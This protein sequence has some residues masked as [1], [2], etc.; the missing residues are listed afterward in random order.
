M[1]LHNLLPFNIDNQRRPAA[2]VEDT[3]NKPWRPMPTKRLT[4]REAKVTM[5]ALYPTAFMVSVYVGGLKQSTTL[6]LLGFWYN[7]RGGS[8]TSCVGRNFINACGFICYS[9]GAM[10]VALGFPLPLEPQ[11]IQWFLIIG[12]VVFSTVQTQDTYDQIGDS[13][14][15]RRTVSLVI[16][17]G[18]ARWLTAAF[19][20]FWCL[21]CP[22]YWT[23]SAGIRSFLGPWLCDCTESIDEEIGERGQDNF[24]DV[25]FL[26]G[27]HLFDAA[28]EAYQWGGIVDPHVIH[29]LCGR[30]SGYDALRSWVE[31][32]EYDA[33]PLTYL[34]QPSATT[35]A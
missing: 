7:D 11:L 26:D 25:E 2:I 5:F 17:D 1:G 28:A 14:R 16:G 10:E 33:S 21:V 4:P 9:S 12:G 34:S 30:T 32:G 20:S 3:L 13:L 18:P 35:P 8:D 31:S 27:V 29:L 6:I 15:G 24:P 19:V 22:W 23:L